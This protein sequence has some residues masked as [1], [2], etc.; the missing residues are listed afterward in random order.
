MDEIHTFFDEDNDEFIK[1][2][3][4]KLF[5][6]INTNK[7]RKLLNIDETYLARLCYWLSSNLEPGYLGE[8]AMS[9][10][11][12]YNKNISK[13][14]NKNL[15]NDALFDVMKN[16]IKILSLISCNL[17][18]PNSDIDYPVKNNLTFNDLTL[19]GKG[20][21]GEIHLIDNSAI[22]IVGHGNL[23]QELSFLLKETTVLA[24][25]GRLRFIGMNDKYYYVGMDYY[26]TSISSDTINLTMMDLAN[27]VKM[28]HDLGIIH[29]DISFNNVKIDNNGV[30]RLID[31]G[32][33]RF[34]ASNNSYGFVGTTAFKDYLLLKDLSE[35][36]N[37]KYI[38]KNFHSYE[39]D[40]WSLGILF[41]LLLNNGKSPW[42]FPNN[43]TEQELKIII[44]NNWVS[45]VNNSS[46]M[47]KGMLSLN[48]NT[49]WNIDQVINYLQNYNV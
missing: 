31:F 25:L 29:G 34:T 49:R 8:C 28:F 23:G 6:F 12:M 46:N 14:K 32:S 33:C 9:F 20:G 15:Q 3:A 43:I 13:E 38:M 17:L 21:F 2:Q 39:I 30:A 37:Y 19:I 44:D 40:I 36:E 48:K 35:L 24:L 18:D 45:V 47:I 11:P 7:I 42:I 5:N 1:E 27:E 4:I 26:P 22:K 16:T 10:L 41:Y